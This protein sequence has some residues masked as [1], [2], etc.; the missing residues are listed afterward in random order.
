MK[1]FGVIAVLVVAFGL[2]GCGGLM[3]KP[4]KA[5]I[6]DDSKSYAYNVLGAATNDELA[7]VDSPAGGLTIP[8][9]GM[10]EEEIESAVR[11]EAALDIG[12]STA[13]NSAITSG[14]SGASVT[15]GGLSNADSLG[16][17]AGL[18]LLGG[19]SDGKGEPLPDHDILIFGW[20]DDTSQKEKEVKKEFLDLIFDAYE[21]AAG[22][23][24]LRDGYSVTDPVK[25]GYGFLDVVAF[26]VPVRGGYCNGEGVECSFSVFGG[27]ELEKT[28]KPHVLG[29][30]PSWRVSA[31]ATKSVYD[32]NRDKDLGGYE[33]PKFEELAFYLEVSKSLPEDFFILIPGKNPHRQVYYT[34]PD[35]DLLPVMRPLLLNEG[36]VRRFSTP[37]R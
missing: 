12:L 3:A 36:K 14:W 25:Y 34:N 35:G 32:L 2:G 37:E 13:Y 17:T 9:K 23:V 31:N 33:K 6:Y 11:K 24:K 18:I 1:Y 20:I 26:S 30:E 16:I 10:P 5:A 27:A 7:S 22:S 19:L 29:G 28:R 15:S 4:E 8:R 21:N